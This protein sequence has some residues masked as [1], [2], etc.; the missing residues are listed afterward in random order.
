LVYT[1]LIG[2]FLLEGL[3]EILNQFI[4]FITNRCQAKIL[5]SVKFLIYYCLS[6]ILLLRAKE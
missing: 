3:V 5:I 4:W 6:V 2:I 1:F